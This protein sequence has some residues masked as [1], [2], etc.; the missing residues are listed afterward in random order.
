MTFKM[1]QIL[2]FPTFFDKIKN[3]KLPFKTSYKL[4]LLTQEMEKH[5]NFYQE[6]FQELIQEY[7]QKDEQGNPK[8][9]ENGMNILLVH[10][11]EEEAYE[12]IN[13]LR[14]IEVELPNITFTPEEFDKLE[15]TVFEMAII[16]P[17]VQN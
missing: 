1:Y 14:D 16:L 6:K 7:S 15:L 10:E 5:I 3:E 17:F 8:Y 12:R 2:N 13:E 11:T 4:A 9:S